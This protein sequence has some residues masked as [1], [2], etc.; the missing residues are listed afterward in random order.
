MRVEELPL[1]HRREVLG[2]E[3]DGLAE[4]ARHQV[5]RSPPGVR[6]RAAVERIEQH[7]LALDARARD[8]VA[9]Q[10]DALHVEARAAAPPR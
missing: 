3:V 10:P 1:R 9:G 6:M 8:E 2:R 4:G 5:A 7:L